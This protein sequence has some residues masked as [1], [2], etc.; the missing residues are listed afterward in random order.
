[1]LS[2][3][4]FVSVCLVVVDSH[5]NIH[6]SVAQGNISTFEDQ[7]KH[8]RVIQN[9]NPTPIKREGS[10]FIVS[11]ARGQRTSVVRVLF[12]KK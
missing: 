7:I 1:M 9:G 6:Y 5:A 10:K 11:L 2:G 8:G 3:H 4:R 12:S